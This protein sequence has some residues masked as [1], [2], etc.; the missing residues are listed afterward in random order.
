MLFFSSLV[1]SQTSSLVWP[2]PPDRVRIKHLQ[3]ISSLK[4]LEAK[5]NFFGKLLSFFA[6]EEQTTRRLVQPV[7]IAV[8]PNGRIYVADP[9][10]NG[11]RKSVV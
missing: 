3:T 7:G 1:Q 11:D 4:N 9:G 10:A 6:G 2:S 8:A 5:K